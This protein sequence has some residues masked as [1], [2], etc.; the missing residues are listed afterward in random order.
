M[1]VPATCQ[2]LIDAN[3][4]IV[5]NGKI[6]QKQYAHFAFD[7]KTGQLVPTVRTTPI[8][9]ILTGDLYPTNLRSNKEIKE[10]FGSS[11]FTYCKPKAL[12]ENLL[13]IVSNPGDI[14]CDPFAGSGTT[15]GAAY[16]LGRSFIL[17]QLEEN[18]IPELTKIRLNKEVGK[19]NYQ[20]C[21]LDI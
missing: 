1:G 17:M 4:L 21:G 13:K 18:G 12:I 6:Y 2:K 11:A 20:V 3:M 19:D 8:R 5:K 16:R 15:G 14:V 7:K 10:I 9:T